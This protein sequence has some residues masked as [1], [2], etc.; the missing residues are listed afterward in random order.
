MADRK[1]RRSVLGVLLAGVAFA[2]P[3]PGRAQAAPMLVENGRAAAEIVTAGQPARM[4]RLAAEELQAY[5]EKISARDCR[6]CGAVGRRDPGLRRRQR[7]HRASGPGSRR[8]VRRRVPDRLRPR[9][10][11]AARAGPGFRA[12]RA[13]GPAP[14]GQ[15]ARRP[16]W[17]GITGEPFRSPFH[18]LYMHYYPDLDAWEF[19]EAGTLNAVHEFLRG[20]GV[21]WYAPGELGEVVPRRADIPLPGDNRVVRPDF[22]ARNLR[23]G[24]AQHG[25][26]NSAPGT[27]GWAS[28]RATGC[29]DTSCP[30]TASSGLP[31]GRRCARRTRSSTSSG[32][33]RATHEAPCLSSEGLFEKHVKYARALLDHYHEPMVNIDMPDGYGGMMCQC[34]L[35]RGKA[36][37][38][39]GTNGAMSDYVWGYLDRVA[40]EIYKSHP[41][42]MVSPAWP[43]APTSCRRRKSKR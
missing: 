8:P 11:G 10:A 18:W 5:I 34:D 40:R 9:L 31:A 3:V 17:A 42:R 14:P 36:T 4:A 33:A 19:D 16:Q 15:R 2:A 7:P 20:L 23:Y 39:R 41:D 26:G 1:I 28:T 6:S 27:C 21:R 32:T 43:T 13:L 24:Y 12:G 37:P 25:L 38:E 35:C 22:A 30:A 29:S